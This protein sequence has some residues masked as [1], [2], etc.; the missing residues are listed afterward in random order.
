MQADR[1]GPISEQIRWAK[2]WLKPSQARTLAKPYRCQ[3]CAHYHPPGTLR[4]TGH[5]CAHLELGT[6][7]NAW[8]KDLDLSQTA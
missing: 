1:Y 5:Y 6:L 8:C 4:P 2:D 3:H 7:A